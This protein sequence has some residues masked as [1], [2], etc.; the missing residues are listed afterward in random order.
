MPAYGVRLVETDKTRGLID[1]LIN[2]QWVKREIIDKVPTTSWQVLFA[3]QLASF[4]E[5]QLKLEGYN[6]LGKH[7]GVNTRGS[8]QYGL[9]VTLYADD[10]GSIYYFG[11]RNS[12][13]IRVH[14]NKGAGR[15]WGKDFK[16]SDWLAFEGSNTG[17]TV[18]AK[19]V[20]HPPIVAVADIVDKCID[21]SIR[22]TNMILKIAN[23]GIG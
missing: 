9:Y 17:G 6:D 13:K 14:E 2:S 11:T 12:Y 18:F 16:D 10:L 8:N 22:Y 21:K 23:R 3:D 19:E 15:W 20:T 5:S 1:Q 4:I 7:F